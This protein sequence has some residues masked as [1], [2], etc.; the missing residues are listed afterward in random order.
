M[1]DPSDTRVI[2]PSST[3][4]ANSIEQVIPSVAAE[5]IVD[6]VAQVMQQ[7]RLVQHVHDHCLQISHFSTVLLCALPSS[8]CV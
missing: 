8:F 3:M 1:A 5:D 2:D 7:Q 4:A 6:T